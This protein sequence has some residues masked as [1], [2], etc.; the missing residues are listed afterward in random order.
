MDDSL[1]LSMLPSVATK[2]LVPRLSS[3]VGRF[4]DVQL[5][6]N[7]S[8]HFT[9]FSREKV[10][11]AIRYGRGRW[12]SV[13]ACLLGGESVFPVCSPA[14]AVSIGLRTPADLSRATL[15]HG[16]IPEDWGLW[17]R[18]VA[19]DVLL[20]P[21]GLHFT[22]DG[23]LIQAAIQGLGVALGRSILTR[24]DLET[25]RLIAPFEERLETQFQYWFVWPS[26]APA[27]RSRDDMLAWLQAE[28]ARC[29]DI[30]QSP[31]PKAPRRTTIR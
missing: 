26:K 30:P 5:S 12:S 16:D 24:D 3:F 7:T 23:A 29:R 28:F 15:L 17:R 8:R 25:G 6:I 14:Y 2:W 13:E 11:G 19:T 10:D 18:H 1:K 20:P 27:K 21:S 9:D 4:P 31:K 22:E